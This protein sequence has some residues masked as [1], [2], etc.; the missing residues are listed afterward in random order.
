MPHTWYSLGAF[1]KK[2]SNRSKTLSH[3]FK[4]KI[5]ISLLL[6][7]IS[8]SC[9]RIVM[10]PGGPSDTQTPVPK[11]ETP[12]NNSTRFASD[13]IKIDFDEFVV[14]V[15]FN[16]EFVSSPL[17]SKNPEVI[18]RGK[19]LVLDFP[20]DSLKPNTTYT[21]DFGNAIADYHAG[22]ILKPYQ[23]VFS[24]GDFI[25]S[26]SIKGVVYSAFD[27]VPQEKTW[28][29]MYKNYSHGMFKT[30]RPDYVAKTDIDGTFQINQIA[31]G[32]Y[33]LFALKD[34]NQNYFF[35]LPNEQIAFLDS[36][37]EVKIEVEDHD[38]LSTDSL[39]TEHH[40]EAHYHLWTGEQSLFLFEEKNQQYYVADHK[41]D[42]AYLLQWMFNQPYDTTLNLRIIDNPNEHW[43]F[44]SSAQ[45]DTMN[46]WI[47]DSTLSRKDTIWLEMGYYKTDTNQQ[48]I[49]TIDTLKFAN[50]LSVTEALRQQDKEKKKTDDS[51][52]VYLGLSTNITENTPFDLNKNLVIAANF[53]ILN[54]DLNRCQ[55]LEKKDSSYHIIESKFKIDSLNKRKLVCLT[56]LKENSSYKIYVEPGAI[57]DYRNWVND[58][59]DAEFKTKKLEAYTEI[60]LGISGIG[61]RQVLVEL[62]NS[63]K[64]VVDSKVIS[65]DDKIIFDYLAPGNYTLKMI[66]D[67]NRNG[68][69]DTG[70]YLNKI[71]PEGITIY[72]ETIATKANWAHEITWKLD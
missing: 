2:N 39:D 27:I 34:L 4:N 46:I 60:Q 62:L 5:W 23:Y 14:L 26:L 63:G 1:V 38:S 55:L 30:T 25:D 21:F 42:K 71:Q 72:P 56:P 64:V 35:D 22:N 51:T 10:P 58:T 54:A 13:R 68:I 50:R 28:V 31:A 17:L 47:L 12:A 70:Q 61:S 18:L 69:W 37:V 8:W 44:E 59:L 41:R 36:L 29:L 24:T 43:L 6:L 40:N 7:V 20:K 45:K 49:W 53:P 9:A 66:D 57:R 3:M 11:A 15:N 48:N 19:T 67:D 65:H 52:K 33:A 16:Q 32:T